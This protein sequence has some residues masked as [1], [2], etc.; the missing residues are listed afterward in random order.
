MR[1]A[2]LQDLE[3]S[4]RASEQAIVSR[5]VEQ[6]EQATAEQAELH[7]RLDHLPAPDAESISPESMAAHRRVLAAGRILSV[8]LKRAQQRLRMLANLVA[9]TQTEYR[10]AAAGPGVLVHAPAVEEE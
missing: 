3:S 5:K 10:P 2:L 6:L 8:L 1:L 7:R 4:L 9:G